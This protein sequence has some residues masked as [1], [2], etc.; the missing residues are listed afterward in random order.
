[1][2]KKTLYIGAILLV[3]VVVAGIAVWIFNQKDSPGEIE[4]EK[5]RV[6]KGDIK[7]ELYADGVVSLNTTNLQFP[8]NG[9]LLETFVQVGDFVEQGA[10]I[11]RLESSAYQN[12]VDIASVR[13]NKAL[14]DQ[15]KLELEY[16]AMEQTADAY[17]KIV[18]DTKKLDLDQSR[19]DVLEAQMELANAK[20]N[21]ADAILE[22]PMAGTIV[23]LNGKVGESVSTSTSD[24]VRGFAV[25]SGNQVDVVA[26]V[27]ELD[28]GSI[29]PGQKVE[30]VTE[31][32]PDDSLEGAVSQIAYLPTTD[33]NGIVAYEVVIT[34]NEAP[35]NLRD[36]MT[37]TVSFIVK[38]VNDVMVL[39]NKA[40]TIMDGEQ[41]VTLLTESGETMQVLIRTGFTD[42]YQVEVKEGLKPG[43]MVLMAQ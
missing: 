1:M 37:C 23:E 29:F 21:L 28:I 27:L 2:K 31:A 32:F 40:V 13:L 35:E 22:A 25:L 26:K 8:T 19:A 14:A 3:I 30:V 5:V 43:D 7:I 24:S 6:T 33:A 36:G 20:S 15:R 39:P 41:T 9:V 11:A 12:E 17:A 4:Q 16:S 34:L 42:G 18:M 38:E 10:P